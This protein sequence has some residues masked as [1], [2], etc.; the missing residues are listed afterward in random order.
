MALHG[1][2]K[3]S[4][5]LAALRKEP[6]E[7]QALYQDLL[8]PVTQFF[9]DPE[10]FEALK[11]Q[12]FPALVSDRSSGTPIRVW[13]AGC[14][15][16]EEVYSLAICLLEFLG[17]IATSYPLKILA[18]DLNENALDKARAGVYLDNIESDVSP[19]RL[20]RFF[21]RSNGHYQISKS[22][23]EQCVFSRH[24]IA[25]DPPFSRLDLVSCRNVLI[26]MDNALQRR[27]LPVLHYALNTGGFLFLGSSENVGPFSEL[28]IPADSKHRIFSKKSQAHSPLPI[29]FAAP[30]ATEGSGRFSR[31]DPRATIW[32]AVDV[33][34]EADRIVLSRYAPVGVVI[35]ETMTVL[36][37]RGRTAPYLEPAPGMASLDLLRMLREGL[38]VDVRHAINQAKDGERHGRPGACCPSEGEHCGSVRVE[39]IPF[40]VPPA[41]V[42]FFLVLFQDTIAFRGPPAGRRRPE[43]RPSRGGGTAGGSSCNRN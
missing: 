18:T 39:V 21:I 35:D 40:K 26:Y 38:L 15:T 10:A 25:G 14:S 1:L 20:S 22:V 19:E 28:F 24:N 31:A 7:L 12:V 30:F 41:G 3:V 36:Q 9:R 6:T 17:N 43:P 8:I 2:E 42:R 32:S 5:Y 33:Q 29:D 11:E 27:V 16:G 13:V 4:D 34:R 37:F 23:R